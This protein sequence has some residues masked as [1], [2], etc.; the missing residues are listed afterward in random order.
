MRFV[1]EGI[2]LTSY[3]GKQVGLAVLP[4]LARHDEHQFTLLMPDLPDYAAIAGRNITKLLV[5]KPR[6]LVQRDALLNRRLPEVCKKA[7]AS[8]LACMGS[9]VPRRLPCPTVAF[10]QLPYLAY[11]EPAAES[12][13]T[14]RERLINAYGR[15]CY[16]RM[17]PS[18][19]VVV[20]TGAVKQ[21]LVSSYGI[22]PRRI[23]SIP[24]SLPPLPPREGERRPAR[25]PSD[26]FTF[27][28]LG[29]YYPHKNVETLL[30]ALR[31]L[32]LYTTLKA[33]CVVNV[34]A[35]HHPGA[36]KFLAKVA[37]AGP[38]CGIV[39]T[40][41]VGREELPNLYRAADAYILPTLLETYS[42]TYDEAMHFG[43][44]ILTSDRDFARERCQ[45]AAIYF[46]PL[47]AESV[48]KAMAR[49]MEDADL[50]ASLVANGKRVLAAASTWDQITAR[51]VEILERV[52]TGKSA[53]GPRGAHATAA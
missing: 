10:L 47:D 37:E 2:G 46:D 12:R 16:R 43:L 40:D 9:F 15:L 35:A 50:R 28:C 49:V 27:L 13:L 21:R 11:A 45:D 1:I 5:A 52:A 18:V 53:Q 32:P 25:R 19:P 36:R 24:Y 29:R 30:D 39:H 17:P 14:L 48:A 26:P 23:C 8:A 33:R 6:G 42:F 34:K 3:G 41:P 4:Q 51:F 7:R 20:Q 22:D 38:D 44:P 31:T